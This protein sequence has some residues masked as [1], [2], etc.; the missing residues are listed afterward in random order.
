VRNIAVCGH[1]V[2]GLSGPEPAIQHFSLNGVPISCG[3]IHTKVPLFEPA[4][5]D[6]ENRVLL[7]VR[8]FSCNYR[9]RAL[10]F[11]AISRGHGNG[12]YVIGSEFVA[13]VLAKGTAVHSLSIGDRVIGNNHYRGPAVNSRS[14]RLLP[15]EGV[16]TNHASREYQILD[17]RKLMKIPEQMPDSVA[18]AFSIGAQT[19]Y[20][21]IRKLDLQPGANVLVTAA[22][23][24]TSLF[25]LAALRQYEVNVYA[26]S[27]SLPESALITS[28]LG[29]KQLVQ[30]H[31]T[32]EDFSQDEQFFALAQTIGGFDCVIDPFF[33]VYLPKVISVMNPG[34]NYV[35]CGVGDTWQEQAQD[36]LR[37]VIGN[38]LLRNVTITA[39]CVGQTQDLASAISDYS[40]GSFRVIVDSVFCGDDVAAFFERTYCAPDRLGKV[41]YQY[42]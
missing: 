14:N 26:I 18:A 7:Q 9:D 22:R 5:P 13:E 21:M 39:N 36:R 41:V 12:Y 8:A 15:L 20:S 3:I 24:N 11:R 32:V 10:I 35:T 27:T 25:A 38:A 16:P 17:A 42:I 37:P 34:S 29:V 28:E 23:S 19:V 33:D 31:A 4:A 40:R 2:G 1:N 6:N 30:V